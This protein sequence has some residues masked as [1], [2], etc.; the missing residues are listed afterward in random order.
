VPLII[1]IIERRKVML[2]F[3]DDGGRLGS[4]RNYRRF[5]RPGISPEPQLPVVVPL[6]DV[7]VLVAVDYDLEFV[8]HDLLLFVFVP[9]FQRN[10]E[11]IG[12]HGSINAVGEM[13]ADLIQY[14]EL[15]AII[16]RGFLTHLQHP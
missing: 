10:I 7:H 9:I 12:A 16:A 1:V 13:R 15:A 5:H 3:A 14:L 4:T 2:T 6:E 11:T 8:L